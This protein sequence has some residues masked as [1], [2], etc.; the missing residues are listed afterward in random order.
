MDTF[1]NLSITELFNGLL[2]DAYILHNCQR[3]YPETYFARMKFIFK[4]KS[5]QGFNITLC[6]AKP[7][8]QNFSDRCSEC[9]T[10]FKLFKKFSIKNMGPNSSPHWLLKIDSDP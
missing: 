8:F 3:K 7:E 1:V 5:V 10:I 6:D 4:I 9:Y 2:D